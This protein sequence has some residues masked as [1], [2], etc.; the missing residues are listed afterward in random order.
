[1]LNKEN[2]PRINGEAARYLL[3][4]INSALLSLTLPIIFHELL[5]TP[6]EVSVG[7]SLFIVFIANFFIIRLFVFR[8]ASPALPEFI[9]F[10]LFSIGFRIGEYLLFLFIF[11]VVTI[12]YILA[13]I[14][15]LSISFTIKFI[16]QRTFVFNLQ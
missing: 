10:F 7:V 16:L 11:R 1:M 3:A 14:I 15:A 4:T 6:E 8:S 9:R 5:Q 12:N 13:L 2:K